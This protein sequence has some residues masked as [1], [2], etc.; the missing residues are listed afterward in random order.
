MNGCEHG[1]SW[2][3]RCAHCS[4]HETVGW[5]IR[6]VMRGGLEGTIWFLFAL[7]AFVAVELL[8]RWVA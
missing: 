1:V 7:H 5:R 8:V 6:E 2:E 4:N 3:L